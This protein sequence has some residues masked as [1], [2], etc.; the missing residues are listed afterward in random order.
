MVL[1]MASRQML[2]YCLR[3]AHFT[4][5]GVLGRLMNNLEIKEKATVVVWFEVP[6]LEGIRKP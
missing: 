6:A 2:E 3:L 4:L 5:G 1:L